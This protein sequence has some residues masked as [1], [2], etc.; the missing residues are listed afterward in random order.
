MSTAKIL[1]VLVLLFGHAVAL[2]SGETKRTEFGTGVEAGFS[3]A[4]Y[5]DTCIMFR[6]FFLSGE[7]FAGLHRNKP[8]DE[9]TFK[10]GSQIFRTFPDRLFVNVEATAYSCSGQPLPMGI[11]G[12]LLSDPVFETAWKTGDELGSAKVVPDQVRHKNYSLRWD[13]FLEIPAKDVPLTEELVVD[14]IMREGTSRCR[15]SARLK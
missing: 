7:F 15:I 8:P 14:V 12:G 2:N 13:Y 9:S 6:V 5:H 3:L 10:K 4:Q 1:T 11:G